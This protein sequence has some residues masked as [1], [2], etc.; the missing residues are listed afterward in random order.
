MRSAWRPPRGWSASIFRTSPP[1]T[2]WPSMV[3]FRDGVPDRSNYRRYR[4][5]TV[6]GQNDFAS[7][8]EVV[9][10]RYSR[11][12]LEAREQRPDTAE[13]SQENPAEALARLARRGNRGAGRERERT[14]PQPFV[15]RRAPAGPGHRGWRQGPALRGLQGTAAA[16]PARAADHRAGQGVRGNLPARARRCRCA[17]RR[18]PA[19]SA[20]S[21][22][23]ATR[24]TALPTATTSC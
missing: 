14:G 22:A 8:A 21:S 5:K 19:R 20:C 24:R 11:V 18:I 7:M 15:R 16:R 17:C 1:R 3:C 13:Y 9:R 2:S 4:I 10:R 6:A 23:S 12:L